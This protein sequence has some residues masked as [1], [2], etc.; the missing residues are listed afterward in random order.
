MAL[1]N[2]NSSRE[3]KVDLPKTCV[4]ISTRISSEGRGGKLKANR[5]CLCAGRENTPR[6]TRAGDAGMEL[7][8]EEEDGGHQRQVPPGWK[9]QSLLLFHHLKGN[10]P[11][12]GGWI[13]LVGPK[14]VLPKGPE[15]PG[16]GERQEGVLH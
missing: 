11:T 5:A 14:L 9:L 3:K 4:R 2:H 10:L 16:T 15:V 7:G 12:R 1:G 6:K 8:C 13:L